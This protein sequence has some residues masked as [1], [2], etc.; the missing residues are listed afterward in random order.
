MT[1][2]LI[3]APPASAQTITEEGV[4]AG[5]GSSDTGTD[6]EISDAVAEAAATGENVEIESLGSPDSEVY[7]APDG[8]FI[9]DVALEPYQ[10]QTSA[11]TW[12]PIDNTLTAS[13]DGRLVPANNDSVLTLSAGGDTVIVRITDVH[14]RS[15]A[16]TWSE[17]LPTPTVDGDTATYADVIPDV[18]LKVKATNDGFVKVFE[19]KTPAAATSAEVASIQLGVELDGFTAAVGETGALEISDYAGNVIYGGPT[20]TMWDAA[21]PDT[22]VGDSSSIDWSPST[23]AMTADV[24]TSFSGGILT[25]TPDPAMLASQDAVYPIRIDPKWVSTGRSAWA[26]V[27]DYP[28]YR[29]RNYYNG[30]SFEKNQNGTARLGRAHRADFSME[31]TWRL[32]F[33]FSTSKFRSRDILD[34][35][36]HLQM[37]YSW[38]PSCSG[39]APSYGIYELDAN[40]RTWTWNNNGSWGSTLATRSEGVDS[41]C[42]APRDIVTDVTDYVSDMAA[43][44][45]RVIQFG[46]KV[47]NEAAC[48]TSFRRFGPEKT[49]SGSGGVHLSV[50]YNTPPNK[51]GSF[52]IDGQLCRSDATVKL[53]AAVSWT[54]TAR[55][56]DDE[57]DNMDAVLKWVDQG[58]GPTKTW[59]TSGADRERATWTVQAADLSGQAYTATVSATDSR[60]TGASAG[61]CSVVVDTT[62]PDPPAVTSS[63]YPDD[64]SPHGSVGKTGLFT[65]QSPSADTAGY[66]WSLQD[67]VGDNTVP[68]AT[69]GESVTI[70]LDPPTDGPLTLSA[71]AYD[72]HGNTSAKTTYTFT[73]GPASSPVGHWRLD[74]TEGTTAPDWAYP[75]NVDDIDR[76]L[77][78]DG[79][80]WTGGS[81]ADAANNHLNYLTFDGSNDTATTASPVIDTDVSYTVSAWVRIHETDIDYTIASQDG[82]V[83]SAFMLKY[84]GESHTFLFVTCNQDSSGSGLFCPSVSSNVTAEAGV[85]YHVTGV[86]DFGSSRIRLYVDG[87]LQDSLSFSDAFDA[88]ESFVLGRDLW[89][90]NHS[91]YFAGDIDEVRVWDRVVSTSELERLGQHAEGIWDF[92][93][94]DTTYQDTSGGGHTLDGTDIEVVEGHTGQGAG[95]NGSTSTATTS[96]PVL[97][98]SGDFTVAA[99]ARLDRDG[100]TAN[101]IS[102]DGTYVSPFYFGYSGG[103]RRWAFRVTSQDASGYSWTTLYADTPVQFGEWTH[104]AAVYRAA[105]GTVHL[106]VN[107]EPVGFGEGFNLWASSGPLRVGAVWH[108]D[109]LAEHWPGAIDSV[110]VNTGAFDDQQ[111]LALA[112]FGERETNSQLV[113][114]HF[115]GDAFV[116]ALAIV[117]EDDRYSDIYLLAGDSEGNFTRTTDPVFE[118]D[119]LNLIEERVWHLDDAVWR[120]GDVNGDGR[121]DLVFAVPG[122]TSFEVWVL[123]A[124]GPNDRICTR[125]G[126][127]F[128]QSGIQQ[129]TLAEGDGWQLT[130]TQLQIGDITGDQRDDLLLLRGDGLGAYSIWQAEFNMSRNNAGFLPPVQVATGSGDARRVE[131]AVGDFDADWWG[132]VAEIRTGADGNADIYLRY[133]SATGLQPPVLAFDAPGDWATDRDNLTLADVTGDGLPDVIN[134]YRFTSRVRVQVATALPDRGGFSLA[135][136]DHSA[137]CTGCPTD[138]TPWAHVRLAGGDIDGDGTDD[139]FTLRAGIGGEIGAMWTRIST[140]SGFTAPQ[141]TWADPTTCFGTSGDVNGDGFRDAVLPYPSYEVSGHADAGAIWFIDGATGQASIVHQNT[142]GINGASET[143]D[144]FGRAVDLYDADGDGCSE[145][146][147]GIPGENSSGGFIQILPGSRNGIATAADYLVDQNTAGIPGKRE[148]GDQF[149]FS[150]A[151]TNLTDGTP[152]LVIGVPGEDIQTDTS[153]AYRDG[154]NGVAEVT[155]GG[156]TIYIQGDVK[157]WVDQ[158]TPGV[159]GG[160]EAGDQFGWDVAASPTRLI[161]GAPF[162]DTVSNT[163]IDA[164]GALVFNHDTS[165]EG[166]PTYLTWLDQDDSYV[167]GVPESGDRV[168]YDVAVVDYWQTGNGPNEIETLYAISSPWEDVHSNSVIDGGL[169]N[170]V[171]Q[172]FSGTY[173]EAARY[174]QTG[175]LGDTAHNDDHIGTSLELV[176][177]DSTRQATNTTLQLVIGVPDEDYATGDDDGLVHIT[178]VATPAA[179]ID[180]I[181]TY[182]DPVTN[183]KFGTGVGFTADRLYITAP[184]INGLYAFDWTQASAGTTQITDAITVP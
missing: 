92:E 139:L 81:A 35:N 1:A 90:G 84:D 61:G 49:D 87:Q 145:I 56:S 43:S 20:P 119:L 118:S 23:F 129:L 109:E 146:A 55:L 33:E 143:G 65:I 9:E 26:M 104:L 138:L 48:C 120:S 57:G 16:Y 182:P 93:G 12:V 123:T 42:A 34:A 95:F 14:G 110:N 30:G 38:V 75:G 155:D 169:V 59:N 181:L 167:Y 124:C 177:L 4:P 41:G 67:A 73:V 116:D 15:V 51:P 68:V 80:Q 161:V 96:G 5:S 179:G 149:G 140:G 141:P 176:N 45:D 158:D 105:G 88:N 60:A 66:H 44:S 111:V 53:G 144:L 82:A 168:G 71:W 83:N 37:T 153:G 150:L 47:S 29:N 113:T 97:D 172:S 166:W 114:G 159:G 86:H 147:V 72:E 54:V 115:N 126:T 156:A 77:T 135:A 132:D 40:L 133:G 10:A 13:G 89:K 21:A 175:P 39:V 76:P 32:A 184:G 102:Q 131:L 18:D 136:W 173:S 180:T 122:N 157:A 164:G 79:A 98:T 108:G 64:G 74:E 94:I 101:L 99:W 62:P 50:R 24:G 154:D 165:P 78:V 112:D 178:G 58:S 17:A 160:V 100:G 183:G 148:A 3:S 163:A 170:V 25:L 36:L 19:V 6:T 151:A 8:T 70:A 142:S 125:S 63:D 106:Y 85:W 134:A 11:G 107:G 2:T 117:E 28:A 27:T 69:P 174:Y 128:T 121:D 46:L 152:V 137:R 7:A 52:T 130:D 22:G 171:K 103:E 127:L 162:E 91:T 31:Q